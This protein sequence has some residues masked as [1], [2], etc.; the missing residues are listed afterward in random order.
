M[1]FVE[2]E[3]WMDDWFSSPFSSHVLAIYDLS[4]L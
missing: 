2:G 3:V 4:H 1:I